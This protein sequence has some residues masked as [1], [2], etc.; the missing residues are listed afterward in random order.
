M[1]LNNEH[2]SMYAYDEPGLFS[3]KRGAIF[4]FVVLLHV[5]LGY[6]LVNGLARRIVQ[7]M[8]P[9]VIITEI[10]KPKAQEKLS[11][12]APHIVPVVPY[13]PTPE[14]V[15]TQAPVETN[16][17]TQTTQVVAAPAPPSVATRAVSRTDVQVDPR[18]PLHIGAEYYPDASR[19]LN[20]EGLCHVQVHVAVDGR[21]SDA[22]LQRGTGFPRL[23]EACLKGVHGQRLLPATEDGKPI[24]SVAVLPIQW[25]LQ[26]GR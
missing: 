9:P 14:F 2:K 23:D 4:A 7:S 6:A 13:V 3:G 18:H 16:A 15:D 8:S 11:L 12:P 22:T 24:E 26:L 25:S 17:I 1:M 21:I 20:E 19:R 5:A 10:D